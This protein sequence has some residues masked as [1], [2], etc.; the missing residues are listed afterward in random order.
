MC[1][2][3]A[4]Q[5]RKSPLEAM[6]LVQAGLELLYSP[7]RDRDSLG[8]NNMKQCW[9]S[10]LFWILTWNYTLMGKKHLNWWEIQFIAYCHVG[11]NY[12]VCVH[13]KTSSQIINNNNLLIGCSITRVVYIEVLLLDVCYMMQ[14]KYKKFK[15]KSRY[16]N[17]Y[18][19][20]T[21]RIKNKY[22]TIKSRKK[23]LLK[24]WKTCWV[25][26]SSL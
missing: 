8:Q 10:Q 11:H 16:K 4:K 2:F 5:L 23:T 26:Y 24:N 21:A 19:I 12:R 13:H 14:L 17:N 20:H 22:L 1:A 3:S 25:S 7:T 9:C 18:N 15:L 6:H